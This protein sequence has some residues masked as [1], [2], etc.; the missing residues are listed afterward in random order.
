MLGQL[1][2][3]R[4]GQTRGVVVALG[5]DARQ[6]L[7]A[8]ERTTRCHYL[9]PSRQ[10]TSRM[11]SRPHLLWWTAFGRIRISNSARWSSPARR[12]PSGGSTPH[13]RN[14]ATAQRTTPPP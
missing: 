13:R 6:P 10:G 7:S 11:L 8:Y 4:G 2:P 1:V 12:I 14:T 5:P 3:V 9:L